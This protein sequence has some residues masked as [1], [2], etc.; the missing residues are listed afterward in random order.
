MCRQQSVVL[1]KPT[2]DARKEAKAMKVCLECKKNHFA[3]QK[4]A[5]FQLAFDRTLK[6]DRFYAAYKKLRKQIESAMQSFGGLVISFVEKEF[7]AEKVGW[8]QIMSV[9]DLAFSLA[10]ELYVKC[11]EEQQMLTSHFA[12]L[13][14][15]MKKLIAAK[16]DSKRGEKLIFAKIASE[17]EIVLLA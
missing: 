7:K 2:L 3:I 1:E 15:L 13:T 12:A 11:K 14:A 16:F 5:E 4:F 17:R 6:V 10:Q 8:R 9:A